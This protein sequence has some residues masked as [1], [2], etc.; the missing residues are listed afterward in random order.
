MRLYTNA[1]LAAEEQTMNHRLRLD[2]DVLVAFEE[3]GRGHAMSSVDCMTDVRK[4]INGTIVDVVAESM[5]LGFPC[6][7]QFERERDGD[8]RIDGQGT[9]RGDM[10]RIVVEDLV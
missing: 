10:S 6:F 4:T 2:G 1:R 5:S 9:V 3:N 7:L 8:G